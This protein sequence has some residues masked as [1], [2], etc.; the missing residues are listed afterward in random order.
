MAF[1]TC[2]SSRPWP[3]R[4]PGTS[5]SRSGAKVFLKQRFAACFER[6]RR[7][8]LAMIRSIAF[9]GFCLVVL[10]SV[11]ADDLDI[12]VDETVSAEVRAEAQ[13]RLAAVEFRSI[14]PRLAELIHSHPIEFGLRSGMD[15]PCDKPEKLDERARIG[16]KL[17]QLWRL[18][19]AAAKA[20]RQDVELML[21]LLEDPSVGE[22]K[23]LVICDLSTRIQN[24]L[25]HYQW[26]FSPTLQ[27]VMQRLERFVRDARGPDHIRG[28]LLGVLL[29]HGAH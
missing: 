2:A 18:H 7:N 11:R 13:D 28:V 26:S 1:A 27:E 3:I 14:I 6:S 20:D 8:R 12:M 19:M 23:R 15:S 17:R 25:D 4:V 22:G 29:P 10:S 21:D 5:G 9:L 24:A 16:C